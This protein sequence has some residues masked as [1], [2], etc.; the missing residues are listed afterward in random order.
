MPCCRIAMCFAC[1]F[2]RLSAHLFF[3][4]DIS[5]FR[6]LGLRLGSEGAG[7]ACV[8]T[9]VLFICLLVLRRKLVYRVH[10]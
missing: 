4:L 3:A 5:G 1:P 7:V 2:R 6:G 9:S 10:S 8:A